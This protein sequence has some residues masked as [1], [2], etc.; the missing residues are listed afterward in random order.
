[1]DFIGKRKIWFTC[2]LIIIIAGLAAMVFNGFTRGKIMNFGIDFT[3]GTMIT[4]RVDKAELD[5][6]GIGPVRDILAGHKLGDSVIQ[7]VSDTDLSIRTEP[8]ET[9]L[10][11]QIIKEMNTKFSK[12]ELLEADVI[13]PTIGKELRGQAVWALIIASL[14]II[15]YVSIRFEFVFAVTALI[16]LYHD[17]LITSGIIAL[18]WRPVDSLFVAALLTILGYSISDTIVIFDRIRENLKKSAYAK[19]TLAQVAN[20]AINQ[21]LARSI[22]TIMTVL[23]MLIALLLFGGATIKDFCFVLLIGFITGGYSSIFIASP[24]MVMWHNNKR[25]SKK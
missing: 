9:E 19:L 8:L 24:L 25:S 13:G 10:R 14:L 16:A 4:V 11:Q 17:L 3:G 2:S 21:T 1:M 20:E 18:L 7:K 15:V 6:Q 12:V 23:I 5:K 22:N